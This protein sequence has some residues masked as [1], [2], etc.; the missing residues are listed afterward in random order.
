M[1]RSKQGKTFSQKNGYFS[2]WSY[3]YPVINYSN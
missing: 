1:K 3:F 2:L